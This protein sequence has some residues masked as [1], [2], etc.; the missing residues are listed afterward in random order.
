MPRLAD[1]LV[2]HG[3]RV[4]VLTFADGPVAGVPG[5]EVVTV[6]RVFLPL[7]YAAFFA[8]VLRL[9]R[10]ADLVFCCEH[11]RTATVTAA[12]LLGRKLVLRMIV[13]TAWELSFRFALTEDDPETFRRRWQKLLARGLRRL[14]RWEL[15]RADLVV[16][17]SEHLG[18][19]AREMGVAPRR[20][21]VVYNLPPASPEPPPARDQARRALGIP[22]G[23]F[24]LLAVA[25]LI[26]WKGLD[27]VLDA[28]ETLDDRFRLAIVG[29]G[30]LRRP[31]AARIARS[32]GLRSRVELAGNRER[33]AVRLHMRASDLLILNSMYEGLSHVLLEA[34]EAGLPVAASDTAGNRELV[35]DGDNGV[36]FPYGDHRRL[37]RAVERLA[38]DEAERSRLAA[39]SRQRLSGWR[40]E[41]AL[42]RLVGRLQRVVRDEAGM[43]R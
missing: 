14:Q 20:L 42:T 31:L 4:T 19:L 17:V 33:E 24:Q 38:A 28:V 16:A 8:R 2:R 23:A 15:R 27:R 11:P 6:P 34:M 25:R 26:P 35:A 7:R 22:D 10:R 37:A 36:L 21:S 1:H 41:H 43:E 32:P 13:D 9:S 40:E 30:P 18:H 12:R 29:D 5:F 39:R 3:H